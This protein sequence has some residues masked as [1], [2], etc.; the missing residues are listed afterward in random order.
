MSFPLNHEDSF[1]K[2]SENFEQLENMMKEECFFFEKKNVFIFLGAFFTKMGGAKY[3]TSSRPS[4]LTVHLNGKKQPTIEANLQ[5][6]QTRNR[7]Y[8]VAM[9]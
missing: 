2:K 9:I 5:M 4:C 8:S 3:A 6:F 1:S 7:R